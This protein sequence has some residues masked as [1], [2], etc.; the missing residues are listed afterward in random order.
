VRVAGGGRV[1]ELVV[2]DE[3]GDGELRLAWKYDNDGGDEDPSSLTN[4]N[5]SPLKLPTTL[6]NVRPVTENHNP[7][8]SRCIWLQLASTFEPFVWQCRTFRK[9]LG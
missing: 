7:S 5:A 9:P 1:C 3:V 2:G 6:L 4:R 8:A